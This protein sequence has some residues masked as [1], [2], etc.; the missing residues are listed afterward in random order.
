[1]LYFFG[2]YASNT[3]IHCDFDAKNIS[4]TKKPWKFLKL[5]YMPK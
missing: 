4:G 3:A 2:L 5:A 1:V